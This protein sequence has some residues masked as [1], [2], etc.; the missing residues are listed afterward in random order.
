MRTSSTKLINPR[1]QGNQRAI[2]VKVLEKHIK[3]W[4]ASKAI[5]RTMSTMGAVDLRWNDS[6]IH[7]SEMN[8][9]VGFQCRRDSNDRTDYCDCRVSSANKYNL[10]LDYRFY[11]IHT[12]KR[13]TS[14]RSHKADQQSWRKFVH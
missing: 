10:K 7:V 6:K 13:L 4:M 3:L 12:Q 5:Q 2:M 9:Y 8:L 1:L 14:R 11:R